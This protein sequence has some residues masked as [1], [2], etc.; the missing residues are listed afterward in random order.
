[1]VISG[2][3]EMLVDVRDG[4]LCLLPALPDKWKNGSLN[5]VRIKG[6]KIL[7]IYWKDGQLADV[8]ER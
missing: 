8:K 1:M 6:G 5:G 2:I 3:L 7:D 4:K